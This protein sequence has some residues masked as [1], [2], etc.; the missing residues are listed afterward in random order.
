MNKRI[1]VAAVIAA[2]MLVSASAAVAAINP[3]VSVGI[4]GQPRV[5]AVTIDARVGQSDDW[6]GRVQIYVP[7]GFRLNAP[8]GGAEVGSG[9]VTAIGTLVG[10]DQVFTMAAKVT[11]I[12]PTDPAVS[13]QTTNCDNVGHLAAWMVQ[14]Q[15]SDDSW[16]F[17]IFVDQTRGSETN[18][19]P[20]KLVACFGPRVT[21]ASN[22]ESNKLTG[23]SL[24]LTGFAT[25]TKAGDYRWRFLWTPFAGDQSSQSGSTSSDTLNQSGSVES[26]TITRI[27]PGALTITAKETPAGRTIISGRLTVS[28]QP[29]RGATI[30]LQHGRSQTKLVSLGSVKTNAAGVFTKAVTVHAATYFRAGTTVAKQD[31]GPGG[32]TMS[33]G[34]PCLD[35]TV[36][37]IA[38]VSKIA[39]VP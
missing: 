25:P 36:G 37:G 33:F 14:A 19:G 27:S 26:Q 21:G 3:K 23:L 31:L 1:R 32:C 28:G 29:I 16:S 24:S 12:G 39:R 35:A 17:P 11:A 20:Y 8:A 15:G 18:F 13:F 22:S 34:V 9:Q 6:I 7:T 5:G 2:A 38:L 4:T 30:A 10:P